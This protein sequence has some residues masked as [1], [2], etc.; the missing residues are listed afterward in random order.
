MKNKSPALKKIP[1][2]KSDEEAED[3]VT[4]ADLTEYDL[5]E[6]KPFRFEFQKKEARVNM[7]LPVSLLEAV[8][9][10][11]EKRGMPYQR[12]IRETIEHAVASGH[13]KAS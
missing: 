4:N 6:F 9:S 2:L 12:F 7:R 1:V 8:K 10:E 5:S 13:K 3:F 11:A